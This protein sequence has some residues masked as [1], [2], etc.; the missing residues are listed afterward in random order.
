[1]KNANW[2]ERHW[3]RSCAFAAALFS[4]LFCG[5][6]SVLA[7]EPEQ[8]AIELALER[9]GMQLHAVDV[10]LHRD[11]GFIKAKRFFVLFAINPE[12]SPRTRQAAVALF[13]GTEGEHW[14]YQLVSVNGK[15]TSAGVL[16]KALQTDSAEDVAFVAREL[17]EFDLDRR[18]A[19]PGRSVKFTLSTKQHPGPA[20]DTPP[21]QPDVKQARWGDSSETVLSSSEDP[22]APVDKDSGPDIKCLEGYTDIAGSHR[23][24]QYTFYRDKLV[25]VTIMDRNFIRDGAFVAS[26]EPVAPQTPE[27]NPFK[28]FDELSS[29]LRLKYALVKQ[30]ATRSGYTT[31][32]M[33]ATK[34]EADKWQYQ[35]PPRQSCNRSELF[36]TP[37]TIIRLDAMYRT[38][39]DKPAAGDFT[40]CGVRYSSKSPEA[41]EFK[42]VTAEQSEELGRQLS[43]DFLEEAKRSGL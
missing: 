39:K 4:S 18:W 22:L 31:E 5:H 10:S 7:G 26:I 9:F 30:D 15:P 14:P 11:G 28:S 21:E 24:I 8:Q 32:W 12:L 17:V 1:M 27:Y 40:W 19:K 35:F 20:E 3:A 38:T 33:D 41:G 13:P 23:Y 16:L 42:R 34:F 43:E 29:L 6:L 2:P 36:E 25:E 37:R